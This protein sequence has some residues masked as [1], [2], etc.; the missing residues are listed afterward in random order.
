M[1]RR[2]VSRQIKIVCIVFGLF[3][4]L[5]TSAFAFFLDGSGHY[6][7]RGFT[8]VDPA[9]SPARGM[10]QAIEQSF[11]LLGEVRSGDSASFFAELR[12]FPDPRNA[13]LGDHGQPSTCN[14]RDSDPDNPDCK[15][16]IQS[17][18]DTGYSWITPKVTQF[19]MRYAFDYC[20]LEAGRR[21]RD[22]GMGIFLDSGTRPFSVTSSTFDGIS[23][24]I[25]LQKF[26][27]LGFSFGYDKLAETG[28]LI[29]SV[30]GK[31]PNPGP[32]SPSDDVD[33]YFL[34]IELD[35]RKTR[36]NSSFNKQIGIYA[37]NIKSSEVK[38]GGMNTDLSFAD[39]YL[40]LYFPRFTF[41]NEF[42]F[43][44]GSTADPNARSL[45]GAYSNSSGE[46]A[47]NKLNAI[48]L[49]G[50]LEFLMSGPSVSSQVPYIGL[51]GSR[52]TSFFEYAI[53]PGDKDGYYSEK[54]DAS[55][56]ISNT[57]RDQNATAMAFNSNFT[58][59]LILFNGRSQIDDLKVDGVFDPK[60]IMNAQ[61][62][63]LGYRFENKDYGNIES[64]IVTAL[65]GQSAPSDV[66]SYHAS[67]ENK[68]IGY[69]GRNLGY[70]LDLK[71]W[72]TF[73][74]GIDA[75]LA[76]GTLMPGAAWRT[77]EDQNPVTSYI[78]QAGLVY[79]F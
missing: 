68:P 67:R 44:L 74:G 32:D 1:V 72:K 37:A 76:A 55:S 71:Y 12:L 31:D 36:P 57:K 10:P 33:Q 27:D 34:S 5:S 14:G 38:K 35:D 51:T 2:S 70:E 64:K 29:R 75:S 9:S 7:V 16:K 8:I 18:T 47:S 61:V 54:T 49:A 41:K 62:Y 30:P 59:A 53:A 40:G 58:P 4:A 11:R 21:P 17:V 77:R 24:T 66:K 63:S 13:Y 19:Y 15:K 43:R 65:L 48:G 46:V 3:S 69:Y 22:W 79:N 45:G 78:F 42:L 26:Q 39:L 28:S 60:R 52:H 23:C 73:T 20:I 6:G 50:T 25:N 56:A